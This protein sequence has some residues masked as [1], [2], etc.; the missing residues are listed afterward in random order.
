MSTPISEMKN[1][2]LA[3]LV[4]I[5]VGALLAYVDN[6]LH[7]HTMLVESV[8][9]TVVTAILIFCIMYQ[10]RYPE[11]KRFG[12]N[13]VVLG[14]VCLTLGS[15]VDILDDPPMIALF[16]IMDVP[17]G[18]SWQQAFI[19][20]IVGYTGGI[21]LIAYGFSRWIPWMI[22]TRE[23]VQRLNQ[24]LSSVNQNMNRVL[25]SLDEHV[26]SERL[27]IA[28]ELHDDVAQQLTFINLQAQLC[29]KELDKAPEE[30]KSRLQ[31][32]CREISE[33]LRNVRQ[34]SRDMRPE[35]L[36][37]LGFVPA[38]EQF[39]DKLRQQNPGVT[40][41]LSEAREQGAEG[42]VR[43]ESRFDERELLHLFRIVQEGIRNA[44]KHGEATEIQVILSETADRF[45]VQVKDN[46]VGLPWPALPPDEALVQE[47]HLGVVGLKERAKEISGTFQL[48]NHPP[49]G[50]LM[51][52]TITPS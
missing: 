19:K 51:E 1:V 48:A 20:K 41:D 28:R 14:L 25:M 17:F 7:L 30:A 2:A 5:V 49:Q 27:N 29:Q 31:T 46:G 11:I 47:G 39:I 35:A 24:R 38:L 8:H 3:F 43:P 50:T 21:S 23:N 4:L 42:H 9:A 26:E 44:L 52:V 15:W 10:I 32:I 45:S 16:E 13:A 36:Y 34:I 33:T 12:W 6:M 37:A 40:I 22:A 18:R